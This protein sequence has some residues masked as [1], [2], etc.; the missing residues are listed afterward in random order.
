MPEGIAYFVAFV[1]IASKRDAMIG[2]ALT[3]LLFWC[4]CSDSNRH[5]EWVSFDRTHIQQCGALTTSETTRTSLFQTKLKQEIYD[6]QCL[7]AVKSSPTLW[8]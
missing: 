5:G 6:L 4:L 1:L 3:T 8:E 2:D 7:D